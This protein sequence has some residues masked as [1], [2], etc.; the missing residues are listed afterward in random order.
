MTLT[1]ETDTFPKIIVGVI[2]GFE[3]NRR[4]LAAGARSEPRPRLSGGFSGDGG[5]SQKLCL[6]RQKRDETSKLR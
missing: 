3:V 5:Y 1:E 6:P 2:I 4:R